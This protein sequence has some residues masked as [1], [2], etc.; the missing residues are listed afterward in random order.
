M[1]THI[2]VRDT[3]PAPP[4]DTQA[5]AAKPK[6]EVRTYTLQLFFDRTNWSHI[7]GWNSREDLC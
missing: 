6:T 2:R 3:M 5:D 7:G 1:D 4:I